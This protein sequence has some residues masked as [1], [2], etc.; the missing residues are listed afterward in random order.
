LSTVDKAAKQIVAEYNRQRNSSLQRPHTSTNR[1]V[2][3]IPVL[4]RTTPVPQRTT[5][6]PKRTIPV[7]TKPP[8]QHSF[9]TPPAQQS[10]FKRQGSS[11]R[12]NQTLY[13]DHVKRTQRRFIPARSHSK[14]LGQ[15]PEQR[16]V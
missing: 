10:S 9:L 8:P 16:F 12:R 7:V 2:R 15:S 5:P 4:Q 3:A 13:S 14:T 11:S 1:S 6:V